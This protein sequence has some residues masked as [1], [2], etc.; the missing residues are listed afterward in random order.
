MI[1]FVCHLSTFIFNWPHIVITWACE[2]F[3]GTL[4]KWY[5]YIL[6]AQDI[7]STVWDAASSLIFLMFYSG[8][9]NYWRYSYWK[10]QTLHSASCS[11]LHP[12]HAVTA[13]C[14][15]SI[16][17]EVT[18]R[19]GA[20]SSAQYSQLLPALLP[21]AW[22][23]APEPLLHQNPHLPPHKQISLDKITAKAQATLGIA[24][25]MQKDRCKTPN[26]Y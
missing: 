17:T 22:V 1:F 10:P 15:P 4:Q 14:F 16:T 21:P 6:C 26:L 19:M 23:W 3:F 12:A 5:Q 18:T 25:L 8:L 13:V 7:F 24:E 9:S 2:H 20:P 11:S